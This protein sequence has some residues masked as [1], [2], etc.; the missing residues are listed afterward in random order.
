M[1]LHKRYIVT[2]TVFSVINCIF[3]FRHLLEQNLNI[4]V[5]ILLGFLFVKKQIWCVTSYN[6]VYNVRV[7]CLFEALQNV[8]YNIPQDECRPKLDTIYIA[9]AKSQKMAIF[10][11]TMS[12]TRNW[13]CKFSKLYVQESLLCWRKAKDGCFKVSTCSYL[14]IEFLWGPVGLAKISTST[15]ISHAL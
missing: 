1:L 6:V 4:K 9:T 7:M 15:E 11:L 10:F 12:V 14:L 5:D 2:F 13:C 8:N 3:Q